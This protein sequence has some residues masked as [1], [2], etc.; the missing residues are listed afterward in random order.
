MGCFSLAL[1]GTLE[2]RSCR[3]ISPDPTDS[4][5]GV[6]SACAIRE[7]APLIGNYVSRRHDSIKVEPPTEV[8]VP[9]LRTYTHVQVTGQIISRVIMPQNDTDAS[10]GG[11]KRPAQDQHDVRTERSHIATE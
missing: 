6:L 2:L 11:K 3:Y 1:T 4:N 5:K 7:L 8:S 10:P 9:G